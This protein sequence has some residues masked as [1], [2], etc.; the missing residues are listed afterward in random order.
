MAVIR[1]ACAVRAYVLAAVVQGGTFAARFRRATPWL[2]AL[3]FCVLATLLNPY[4]WHVYE[5]VMHNTVTSKIR[6]IDEWLP[7]GTDS[8]MGKVFVASLLSLLLLFPFSGRRPAIRDLCALVIFLPPAFGAVR[9]VGWWLLVIGPILAGQLT[10]IWPWK[11]RAE[12]ERPSV[13]AAISCLVLLTAMVLSLP[14]L[15]HLNPLFRAQPARAARTETD[16]EEVAA[17]LEKE[18]PGGVF[19][20]FSWSEYLG[21]RLAPRHARLRRR[22]HRDVSDDVWEAYNA[23]VRGRADWEKILDR[24][25]VQWL[26]LDVGQYHSALLP[27]VEASPHWH[28][29]PDCAAGDAVVFERVR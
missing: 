23:V 8:L 22:P 12:A 29:R 15:E 21:W 1:S 2:L 19:S 24:Y 18:R 20:R 10:A 4:G 27:L 17:H 7:T 5:Y 16:L 9:M 13:G 3:T 26:V 14:W 28:M 11:P 6:H 25:D